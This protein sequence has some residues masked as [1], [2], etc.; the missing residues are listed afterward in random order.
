M[1]T[2]RDHFDAIVIGSGIGGLACAVAL[3][4][5]G[6]GVLVLERQH[7]GGGLTQSFERNGFRCDVGLHYLGEMGTQGEARGIIDWLSG[8]AITFASLSNAYDI[9]HFPDD[10]TVPFTRPRAALVH[11]LKSRFPESAAEVDVFFDALDEAVHAG[12][13]LFTRRALSGFLGDV[14]GLWHKRDIPKWWGRTT[15][16]VLDSLI[17]DPRLRAVLLAQQGNHGGAEPANT[18]FGIHAVVMN[19]YL[20]GGWYPVGGARVFADTLIPVIE[21]A[22]GAVQL[23]TRVA[24]QCGR[25]RSGKR[26]HRVRRAASASPAHKP[27]H[28]PHI[29]KDQCSLRR[30]GDS[31][32]VTADHEASPETQP[33]ARPD[34]GRRSLSRRLTW[35]LPRAAARHR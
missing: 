16:E 24:T 11:E 21:Q 4:R 30:R 29:D 35:N 15:A 20:N 34:P 7:V 33:Q 5:C 19:H 18:S 14:Y 9:V 8:N 10:F 25:R 13:A 3:A 6:R 2:D 23:N 1:S 17:S 28:H 32:S 26:W 31:K 22:G 27:T 12:K